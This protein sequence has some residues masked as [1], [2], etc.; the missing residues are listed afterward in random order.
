MGHGIIGLSCEREETSLHRAR[1]CSHSLTITRT[2]V[3]G[4]SSS[5]VPNREI[6]GALSWQLST[7]YQCSTTIGKINW[8]LLDCEEAFNK[9]ARELLV[10]QLYH[11]SFLR[12][13]YNSHD[14]PSFTMCSGNTSARGSTAFLTKLTKFSTTVQRSSS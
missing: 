8:A 4:N 2:S 10:P 12:Y 7:S 3:S 5:C 1:V 13:D 6:L 11:D 9:H 14:R